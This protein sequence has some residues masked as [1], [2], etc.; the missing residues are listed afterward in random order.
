M[1]INITHTFIYRPTHSCANSMYAR[2][3]VQWSSGILMI[4]KCKTLSF[5]YK[6]NISKILL[7]FCFFFTTKILLLFFWQ[8]NITLLNDTKFEFSINNYRC[9]ISVKSLWCP[10]YKYIILYSFQIKSPLSAVYQNI[11]Q[12]IQNKNRI[13]QNSQLVTKLSLSI[14]KGI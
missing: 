14:F 4:S 3:K 12:R 11:T 10:N 5:K 6:I 8:K 9:K 2:D 1:Y 7:C 13:T